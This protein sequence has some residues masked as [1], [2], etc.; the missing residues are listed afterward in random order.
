MST[1]SLLSKGGVGKGKA[2]KELIIALNA[3]HNVTPVNEEGQ[4]IL[5]ASSPDEIALV[6]AAEHYG[7]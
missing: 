7:L 6:E 5:Q 2:V 4:R 1:H 3:C